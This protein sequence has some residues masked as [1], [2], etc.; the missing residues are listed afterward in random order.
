[1]CDMKKGKEKCEIL[2]TIRTQIAQKYG[3]DYTPTKCNNDGD[4]LGTCP[5]C[6]AEL[7]DLQKQLE[8]RGITDITL[9]K[10]FEELANNV[11]SSDS[12]EDIYMPDQ[13]LA[14]MIAPPDELEELE[15]DIICPPDYKPSDERKILMECPVAGIG[16]HDI[17]NVWDE[18]DV[19]DKVSLVRE[20]DNPHDKNAVAIALYVDDP[21]DGDSNTIIGYI[22]RTDNKAVAALI[23][24][25][26]S[27]LLEAEI[28]EKKEHGSNYDKL[29]ITV[30]V[31]SHD[32]VEGR[33]SRIRL[34]AF[35]DKGAWKEF[36]DDLW[37]MGYTYFRWGG[38][39]PWELDL[40]EK[41][42]KVVFLYQDEE[43]SLLYLMKT[44]A[45]GEQCLPYLK[46]KEEL[47]SVDDCSPY[48][49]TNIC[50]KIRVKNE[51]LAFL[52]DID[53]GYSQPDTRLSKEISEK[54]IELFR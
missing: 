53:N 48:V 42:N 10:S 40:P 28:S 52:G 22:P 34:M 6:E 30:Y 11:G 13:H 41:G 47:Y 1:M 18:L 45:T 38:F 35:S 15:G 2:K 54:L 7:A 27:N 29:H 49:L 16:F 24:M 39:P 23:D 4:C 19:G 46:N 44:I 33:E 5:K 17:E 8:E 32:E 9:D 12:Q 43:E 25:G 51:D 37:K 14:G 31:K 21:D 36:T 3:L 50:G 26:W 20:K